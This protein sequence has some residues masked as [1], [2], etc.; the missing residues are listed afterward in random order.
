MLYKHSALFPTGWS[1]NQI[2]GGLLLHSTRRPNQHACN[3]RFDKFTTLCTE[4]QIV[5]DEDS[6]K[7]LPVDAPTG[8]VLPYGIDP[9]F[10]SGSAVYDSSLNICELHQSFLQH[11]TVTVLPFPNRPA[12]C[13]PTP[14]PCSPIAPV[15]LGLRSNN[16][17]SQHWP[18]D[19]LHSC[20]LCIC[21]VKHNLSLG[22]S[23]HV[24]LLVRKPCKC[25][26]TPA[27]PD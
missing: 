26:M 12:L 8:G 25:V 24:L 13:H 1:G 27:M 17:I 7:A 4:Q 20:S 21:A 5:Y 16:I 6:G 19:P 22:I 10:L 15:I 14:P 11:L 18:G 3:N 23:S 9:V 2:L